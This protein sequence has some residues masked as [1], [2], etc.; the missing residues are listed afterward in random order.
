MPIIDIVIAAAIVTSVIV[1]IIRGFVKEA[2][3]IATL[4]LAIWLALFFGPSIGSI[5]ESWIESPDLQDWFGRT[6]IFLIV[7][8]LG[9][10]LGWGLAKL[11]RMSALGGVDRMAG[12]IF[13]AIRGVLLAALVILVGE[14]AELDDNRWWYQSKMIPHLYVV[15]DWIQDMAP[16]G[17]ELLAPVEEL[18]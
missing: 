17:Y 11:V 3:S 9:G 1:G 16:K 6:L 5:S 10:L 18:I 14:F 8:A 13:G 7:L 15:A 4:L 2:I 12:S